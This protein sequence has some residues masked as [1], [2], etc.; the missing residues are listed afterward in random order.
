M[1]SEIYREAATAGAPIVD[2][3]QFSAR[4]RPT[5]RA[6]EQFIDKHLR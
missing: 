6:M 4:F 3:V 5:T 1:P 2:L